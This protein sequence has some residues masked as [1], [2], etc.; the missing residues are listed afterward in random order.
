M[1]TS[2]TILICLIL[3]L[4]VGQSVEENAWEKDYVKKPYCKT[5]KA[6]LDDKLVTFKKC[7]N[8]KVIEETTTED[9]DK[10]CFILDP[11]SK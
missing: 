4:V 3:G 5:Y 8:I 11:S 1:F 9:C 2:F 7:Y 6:K 10:E